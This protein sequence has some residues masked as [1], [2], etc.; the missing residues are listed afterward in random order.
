M[1][2]RDERWHLGDV[3]QR[4]RNIVFPDT[5]SNETR[6]WRNLYTGKQHLTPAQVVGVTIFAAGIL[7]LALL[8]FLEPGGRF[9]WSG[10][11]SVLV[12]WLIAFGILGAFL[13]AFRV[14]DLR[15][16]RKIK[17]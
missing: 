11:L 12:D 2:K 13:F 7:I 6:F 5:V 16:R 14:A 17:K 1:A 10:F 3:D 9:S 4:Q 15:G 8:T